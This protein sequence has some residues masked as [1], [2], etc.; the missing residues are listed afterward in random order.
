VEREGFRTVVA[1]PMA[2]TAKGMFGMQVNPD[3]ALEG[4]CSEEFHTVVVVGR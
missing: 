2:V 3:T 4:V 1:S